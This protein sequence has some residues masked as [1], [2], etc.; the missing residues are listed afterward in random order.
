[1]DPDLG[2][3][4]SN[5]QVVA[6]NSLPKKVTPVPVVQ[7]LPVQYKDLVFYIMKQEIKEK[8]QI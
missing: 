7:Y 5:S 1:M 6:I 2:P 3:R 4:R 8:R